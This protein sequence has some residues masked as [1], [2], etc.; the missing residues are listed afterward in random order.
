MAGV[1]AV[2]ILGVPARLHPREGVVF[3]SPERGRHITEPRSG[4]PPIYSMFREC[5]ETP[6]TLPLLLIVCPF[7]RG[8]L[9][10]CPP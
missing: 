9:A 8:M 7:R 4:T 1:V 10:G 6:P 5:V 2:R 3:I